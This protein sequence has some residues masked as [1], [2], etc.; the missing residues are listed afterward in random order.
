MSAE[1]T[2]LRKRQQIANANRTMFLWV[3]A[4]SVVVGIALVAASFLFNK[5]VFNERVLAEKQHT[6]SVLDNNLDAVD[7]LKDN[8][9]VLNTNSALR[10]VMTGDESEPV[11]VVLDALPAS[12]NSTA[13]GSS[14]QQKFL[15][16]SGLKVQSITITPVLGVEQ[17]TGEELDAVSDDSGE[18]S[19]ANAIAFNFVVTATG[20]DPLRDLLRQLEKSIRTIDVTHMSLDVQ[21]R[22]AFVLTVDGNAFYEPAK[23]VKLGEKTV[24]P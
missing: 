6:S 22:S 21:N 7:E 20:P 4:A 14:L 18:G 1:Q 19:V 17:E 8:I 3:A 23:S 24:K 13:L 5:L 12:A 10:S 16:K 2:G 15:N 9:R 11:Q